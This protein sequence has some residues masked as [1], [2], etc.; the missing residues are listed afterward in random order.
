MVHDTPTEGDTMQTSKNETLS[1]T[2]AYM[3]V[4]KIHDDFTHFN[5]NLRWR[6]RERV[7]FDNYVVLMCYQLNEL[8][9]VNKTFCHLTQS[10][11]NLT[12]KSERL[13][14]IPSII[15]MH[16]FRWKSG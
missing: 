13:S 12:K 11:L 4:R 2:N 15:H 3:Y 14:M 1:R 9:H 6:E 5:G 16:D 8:N 7:P 10:I